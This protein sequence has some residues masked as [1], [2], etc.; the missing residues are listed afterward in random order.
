[1]V[2]SLGLPVLVVL[3]AAA[4][5]A[6]WVAGVKVSETTD[7]LSERLGLGEALGGLIVLATAGLLRGLDRVGV[8]E[9]QNWR[10]HSIKY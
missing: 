8:I 1:M 2:A 9:H 4:A 3:F 7:V 10:T 6:V 5:A